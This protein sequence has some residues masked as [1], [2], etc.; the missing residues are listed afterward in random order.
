MDETALVSQLSKWGRP[1]TQLRPGGS[2]G[3]NRVEKYLR[4]CIN[5]SS[6]PIHHIKCISLELLLSF[7]LGISLKEDDVIQL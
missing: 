4:D 7:W 5:L 6:P 1:G 3:R 2:R